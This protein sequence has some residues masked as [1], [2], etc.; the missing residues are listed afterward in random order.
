MNRSQKHHFPHS[1][2]I[3][4]GIA[5]KLLIQASVAF[6]LFGSCF[7]H[8]IA[9]P[10]T[11]IADGHWDL[12]IDFNWVDET[13]PELGG[14]W[15]FFLWS[16]A[17][18]ERTPLDSFYFVVDE[19]YRDSIPSGGSWP[20]VL[21][22]AGN[23]R[24][25]LAQTERPEE[26]YLGFRVFPQPSGSFEGV[27]SASSNGRVQLDLL[28]VTGNGR[29]AGGDY[30]MYQ[31]SGVATSPDPS[32]IF[33]STRDQN[34]PL[35][36]DILSSGQTHAHF[37]W[38][39]TAKGR[40]EATFR[41]T[42]TIRSTGEVVSGEGRVAFHVNEGVGPP[43]NFA[44]IEASNFPWIWHP[45]LG[46]LYWFSQ[47]SH[48]GWLVDLDGQPYFW[49]QHQGYTLLNNPLRGNWWFLR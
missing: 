11:P 35:Q 32:S 12:A 43:S 23:P 21:G 20:Q 34:Q 36:L 17:D 40:Y 38:A 31:L 48:E 24:W 39:M 25:T 13:Q 8:L 42:G 5:A 33:F 22:P 37:A 4:S 41:I 9:A 46:W 44:A 47:E 3:C 28:E 1:A 30:V 19:R 10:R 15:E 14:E 49:L 2:S 29:E 26:I 45:D 7:T 6:F 16:P 27:T 18:Q